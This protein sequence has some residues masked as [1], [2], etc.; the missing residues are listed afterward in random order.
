MDWAAA[1]TG[2]AAAATWS[3]TLTKPADDWYTEGFSDASWRTGKGGFGGNVPGASPWST[4]DIWVRRT[5]DFSGPT[6]G[7]YLRIFHDEDAEVYLNGKKIAQMEGYSTA[8]VDVPMDAAMQAALKQG[9]NVLAIHVHQ[10][11]GGQ[12]IDAGFVR[13]VRP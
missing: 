13:I 5:F 2:E 3:Y 7:L 9:R 11:A 4:S 1:P 8:Y 12:G 10:T 6:E